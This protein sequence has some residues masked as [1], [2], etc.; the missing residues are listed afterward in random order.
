MSSGEEQ[1]VVVKAGVPPYHR[2]FRTMADG[3]LEEVILAIPGVLIKSNLPPILS[4]LK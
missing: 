4:S 3:G 2:L 1:V